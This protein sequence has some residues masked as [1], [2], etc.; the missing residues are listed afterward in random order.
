MA[1]RK[2]TTLENLFNLNRYKKRQGARKISQQ[3]SAVDL[4]A[5]KNTIIP[6][7]PPDNFQS[8]MIKD[9]TQHLEHLKNNF[10]GK[11]EICYYH[12]TLIVLLRREAD[13][14]E[15]FARFKH[16]WA[17]ESDFLLEH[18]NMR[19]LIAAVDTFIDHD[20]DET[21]RAICLNAVILI[22]T[23][24][25]YETERFLLDIEKTTEADYDKQRFNTTKDNCFDLFDE[26]PSFR[27]GVDDTLRNMRWRID[28]LS[29]A[30]PLAGKILLNI[31]DRVNTRG[32]AYTRFR[33][34]HE[35]QRNRWWDDDTP[36]SR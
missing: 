5:L 33:A 24:K 3:L 26:L 31:F 25:L 4:T 12:A 8:Y 20:P 23:I 29:K 19:W 6:G 16:L 22:N 18:L 13:I 17:S 36:I 30:R 11:P 28:D 21:V 35:K 10:I 15:N 2:K 9:L 7:T 27:V 34:R 32:S 14:A 1:A